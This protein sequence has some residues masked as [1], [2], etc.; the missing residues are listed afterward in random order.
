METKKVK[1]LMLRLE[2]YAIV[3]EDATLLEAA[4]TLEEAQKKLDKGRM[5]HRAV[6]VRDKNGKI[7]GKLG[8]LAFL[9][10]L[11]PQYDSVGQHKTLSRA[12]LSEEFVHSMMDTFKFW[13]YT[14]PD[15]CKRAR[16]IKVKN[17][18]HPITENIDVNAPITEAVHKFVM[19]QC[20]SIPVVRDD[21]IVGILRLSD[22]Y[23]ELSKMIRDT[24]PMDME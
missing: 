18:A 14:T 16:S 5:K 13:E 21:E 6:L 2:D 9:K 22:L 4:I 12:G 7:V 3:D 10:A 17:A 24:C 20:L 23:S 15:L 11:E 19:W 1:D 8:H